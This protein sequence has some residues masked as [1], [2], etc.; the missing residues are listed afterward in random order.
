MINS[1]CEETAFGVKKIT[2]VSF[3]MEKNPITFHISAL[4]YVTQPKDLL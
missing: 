3:V 2:D 1:H 4:L